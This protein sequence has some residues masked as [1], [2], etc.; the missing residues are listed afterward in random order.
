MAV[1]APARKPPAKPTRRRNLLLLL[2]AL[3]ACIIPYAIYSVR[4][5]LHQPINLEHVLGCEPV[6][7]VEE[8]GFF[9]Q[10]Q[11]QG[12]PFRW[13]NGMAKLVVPIDPK[14]PPNALEIDFMIQKPHGSLLQVFVN[15]EKVFDRLARPGRLFETLDL[16]AVNLGQEVVIEVISDTFVPADEL[17][18][19]TDPRALGV[20]VKGI[21]LLRR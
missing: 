11:Y 4:K 9:N 2:V 10:E 20:N 12:R 18:G 14:A 3:L 8:S 21:R 7:E 13:T 5:G 19:S 1:R 6:P 16:S 17:R 15:G